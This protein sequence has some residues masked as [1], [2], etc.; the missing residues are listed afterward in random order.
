MNISKKRK[1]L[2]SAIKALDDQKIETLYQEIDEEYFR[3]QRM[4]DESGDDYLVLK[5]E[6]LWH[7]ACESVIESKKRS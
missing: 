7:L 1:E 5:F 3:R 4:C 6:S 2:E